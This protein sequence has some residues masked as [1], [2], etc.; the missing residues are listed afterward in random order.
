M[1]KERRATK[2]RTDAIKSILGSY[3]TGDLYRLEATLSHLVRITNFISIKA[4]LNLIRDVIKVA[5]GEK[6][7]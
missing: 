4:T 5:C 3:S 6:D 7:A 1:L 2:P